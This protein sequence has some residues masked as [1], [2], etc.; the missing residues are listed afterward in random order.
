MLFVRG[1]IFCLGRHM[2]TLIGKTLYPRGIRCEHWSVKV[3]CLSAGLSASTLYT[4]V[5]LQ[6]FG[7][8]M[9]SISI[10]EGKLVFLKR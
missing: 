9:I 8:M 1:R 7:L 5:S 4:F 2:F 10:G 6:E 3:C